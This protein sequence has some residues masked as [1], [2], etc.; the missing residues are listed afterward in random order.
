MDIA[1]GG[2]AAAIVLG[3]LLGLRHAADADHV[4]AVSTIVS[5]ERN[6]WRGLW[7][8]GFVGAGSQHAATA[9]GNGH[10]GLQGSSPGS[11]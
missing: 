11:V 2:F 9:L 5:S 7:G 6:V 1:T 8:W 10:F 3:F 4:V